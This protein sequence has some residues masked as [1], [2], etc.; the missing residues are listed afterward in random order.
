M[1]LQV[2]RLIVLFAKTINTTDIQNCVCAYRCD[3]FRMCV[4]PL[5]KAS[6]LMLSDADEQGDLKS[7]ICNV[8]AGNQTDLELVFLH[9]KKQEAACSLG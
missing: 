6:A 8:A 7:F 3:P 9:S 5:G 2:Y 1:P 4:D